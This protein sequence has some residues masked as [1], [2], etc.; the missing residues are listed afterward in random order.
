VAAEVGQDEAVFRRKKVG[1]REP[2]AVIDGRGME[3]NDG[4]AVADHGEEE[5]GA[6]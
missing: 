2:E 3:E 6:A 5:L 4:V 1:D